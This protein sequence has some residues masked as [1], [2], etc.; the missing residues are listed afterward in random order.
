[1]TTGQ[2]G[3]V[4][5]A[6]P[7]LHPSSAAEFISSGSGL[8]DDPVGDRWREIFPLPHAFPPE[9]AF[10]V[11]RLLQEDGRLECGPW[12]RNPTM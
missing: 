5:A 1:M 9:H 2:P 7:G 6:E 3:L 11:C 12:W 4:A 10:Q 8:N